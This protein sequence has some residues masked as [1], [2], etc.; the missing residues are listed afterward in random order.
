MNKVFITGATGQLGKL[1]IDFLLQKGIAANEISA[2]A[3]SA[4]KA[5]ELKAKGINIKIGDYDNYDSLTAAFKG[6][7][8]LLL[9]S[10]SEMTKSRAVQ[11]INAINAA[12]ECG[13]KH[14]IYTGYMRKAED[15]NSPLWF[16]V[17]DHIDTEKHLKESGINYTLFEN[18]Y[19][20]D[21]LM[22]FIGQNILE[23][24][25]IFVP[26]KNGKINFVLRAD[27]AEGLANVVTTN[28]HENKS[29]NIGSEKAVS[30]Y[31]VAQM[32]TD[33]TETPIQYVSPEPEVYV[34]TLIQHGV[35][36]TWANVFSAFA[37]AFADNI[38]NIDTSDLSNI[39]G[40]KPT[41]VNEFL[42]NTLNKK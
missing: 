5:E 20:L 36:E 40:R 10:S 30:F 39:L 14:I 37:V 1:T 18:G 26:A 13:V 34:K 12:K 23:T 15:P 42:K 35:P 28:G 32:I 2:L 11:H 38:M 7:E 22:D 24:K 33:I 27:I 4:E 6:V 29:Y 21:M 41:S 3:R 8:K 17:K 19:Y 25:T 16:L 9:I 31:E